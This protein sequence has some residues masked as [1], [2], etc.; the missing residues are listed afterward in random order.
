VQSAS[1]RDR[2]P[3]ITGKILRDNV[4]KNPLAAGAGSNLQSFLERDQKVEA[5][6]SQMGLAHELVVAMTEG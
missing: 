3:G 6:E 1:R 5:E 2:G 4:G